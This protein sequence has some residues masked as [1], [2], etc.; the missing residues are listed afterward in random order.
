[1]TP[2]EVRGVVTAKVDQR[3]EDWKFH[4]LLNGVRCSL[5]ANINRT[6]DR[7]PFTAEDFSVLRE[8]KKQKPTEELIRVMDRWAKAT[9]G[10]NG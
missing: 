2:A 3:T 4:N 9:G 7:Q 10:M 8:P 1:M 6:N 5:L